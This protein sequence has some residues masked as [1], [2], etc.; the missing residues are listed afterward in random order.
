MARNGIPRLSVF[1]GREAKLN[2]AVLLILSQ[3]NPLSI[4]QIHKKV[5]TYRGLNHTRYRVVNRRMKSLEEEGY[6]ERVRTE[7]MQQGFIAKLYQMTLRAY[8]AFALDCT[9]IDEL[10]RSAKEPDITSI[11]AVLVG[12][13]P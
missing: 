4:R 12:R 9:D 1:K 6:I 3:E 13:K 8:L 10:V 7:K 5:R 2:R 11:L